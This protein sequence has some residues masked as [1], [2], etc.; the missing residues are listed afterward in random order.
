M[1]VSKAYNGELS[2]LIPKDQTGI[3]PYTITLE[4]DMSHQH[5]WYTDKQ[6]T[7]DND[8]V[9]RF[10]ISAL[11]LNNSGQYSLVLSDSTNRVLYQDIL[12][13]DLNDPA[14]EDYQVTDDDF[15]Y[16]ANEEKVMCQGVNY[17]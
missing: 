14:S 12:T 2:L 1:I 7:S 10:V 13:V 17:S 16:D 4:N 6:D 5:T 3:A 9:Y 8:Y 15:Y 11:G